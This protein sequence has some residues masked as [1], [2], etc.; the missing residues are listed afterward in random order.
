MDKKRQ[1]MIVEDQPI[2]ADDIAIY[3]EQ[4]GH[5]VVGICDSADQALAVL[6]QKEV[7]LV[8]LDIKI[9]GDKDGIQLAQLIRQKR[10]V[11][12]I[13]ISSLYDKTTITRAKNA[14]PSGY[15]VKPFKDEDIQVAVDMALAK[16]QIEPVSKPNTEQLNLFVRNNNAIVPLDFNQVIYVEASDNYSIF[17]TE[18]DKYVVSQTLKNVE[19]ILGDQ[20]YCRI[21]KTFLV[22]L[23]KI[24]RIEHSVVFVNGSPLPIGKV[25]R[26]PFM[27]RLTVF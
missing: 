6:D 5:E 3:L 13:F 7:S 8:L 16:V 25:Y 21:H 27:D 10:A 26:K 15:I 24:D 17:Y 19:D 2:I 11:P 20:G 23:R 9:K 4:M 12:F 22:N 18:E 1:I 14:S